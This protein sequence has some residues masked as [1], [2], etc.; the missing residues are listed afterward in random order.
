MPPENSAPRKST[1][2]PEN[3]APREVHRAARE[4]GAGE[5]AAVEDD[6]GEVKVAALPGHGRV[7]LEV[8]G[9]DPD[10]GVAHLAAGAEGQPLRRRC[11]LAR[12]GLVGHAQVGAQHVDAGLPV[13]PPVIGQARHGMHPGQ[14]HGGLGVAELRG[15]RGEPL[16]EHPRAVMHGVGFGDL[17]PPVGHDQRDQRPRTRHRREHQLQHSHR[18]VQRD[19]SRPRQPGIA[20]QRPRQPGQAPQPHD[21]ERHTGAQGGPEVPQ[22]RLTGIPALS[23]LAGDV[24]R[25]P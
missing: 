6:A 17:L 11:P 2:P 5:S 1:V 10:D 13:R 14:P 8:G 4:H 23:W 22:P 9:D 16:V 24:G 7:G 25:A 3:S 12:V 18:V 19:R 15:D 21:R 20:Q